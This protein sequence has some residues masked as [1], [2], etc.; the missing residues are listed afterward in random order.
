MAD[1]LIT[2]SA[3]KKGY[4]E[5]NPIIVAIAKKTGPATALVITRI[6]SIGLVTALALYGHLIPLVFASILYLY[7]ALH[8]LGEMSN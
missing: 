2:H 6:V 3:I 5:K 1:G 7:A 4:V 8:N